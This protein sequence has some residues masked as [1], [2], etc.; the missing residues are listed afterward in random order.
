MLSGLPH[1]PANILLK[2]GFGEP[3]HEVTWTTK[4]GELVDSIYSSLQQTFLCD[5]YYLRQNEAI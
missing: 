5:R 4:Q 2:V 3:N 1:L